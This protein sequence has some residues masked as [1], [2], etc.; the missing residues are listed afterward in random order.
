[1]LS[2]VGYAAKDQHAT[3]RAT[4]VENADMTAHNLHFAVVCD[5]VSGVPPPLRAEDLARDMRDCLRVF[6][7]QRFSPHTSRQEFDKGV[8]NYLFPPVH[9]VPSTWKAPTAGSWLVL[10]SMLAAM[11]TTALGS[12]CFAVACI[13]GQK[14]T[15]FNL[16]DCTVALFRWNYAVGV[17]QMLFKTNESRVM[18]IDVHGNS[19]MGPHQFSVPNVA[20][21]DHAHVAQSIGHGEAHVV[22]DVK[23][24]D[25]L[26]V[27]SDGVGDNATPS[28]LCRILGAHAQGDDRAVAHAILDYCKRPAAPKPDDISIFVGTVVAA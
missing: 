11:H 20:S 9:G 7:S 1:M 28:E 22:N 8:A 13:I 2:L 23:Q 16:G 10:L 19:V 25:V 26:M 15:C 17:W 14:L 21:R 3:K 5:G 18:M 4:G 27:Y 24:S 12:T 6:L